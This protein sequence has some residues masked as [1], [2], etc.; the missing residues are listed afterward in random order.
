MHALHDV[1]VMYKKPPCI[2]Q[3]NF[4]N[5]SL[6]G[7]KNEFDSCIIR[8]TH[9]EFKLNIL[10]TSGRI[11]VIKVSELSR[12]DCIACDCTFFMRSN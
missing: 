3:S 2:I 10:N 4:D 1:S 8:V 7:N 5:S 11:R 9:L 6:K 12:L